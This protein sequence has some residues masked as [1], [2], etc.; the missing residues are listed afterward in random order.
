MK[1]EYIKINGKTLKVLGAEDTASETIQDK[2]NVFIIGSKGIPAQYGGFETFVDKLTEYM[3]KDAGLKIHVACK[4]NGDGC[5]DERLIPGVKR[6]SDTEFEYHNAHCFKIFVPSIGPAAAI[7]YDLAALRYC[8]G[9]CR[10]QGVFA[11]VV[12]VLA[13]RIGPW[14]GGIKRKILRLDGRLYVNPD[15]HEW[16][17][18]KW[19]WAVRRYWKLSERLTVKQADLVICDSRNIEAYI[20]REYGAYR[21]RTAFIAY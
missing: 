7:W 5:M 10:S 9:Y 1:D 15:G 20:R 19:P 6:I 12:Y 8:L 13:C 4:A 21:P 3:P 11:P 14:I 2:Q 18:K 17:R 16:L